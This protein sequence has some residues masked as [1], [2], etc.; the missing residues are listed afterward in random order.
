MGAV[1]AGG[2]D[3]RLDVALVSGR[4]PDLLARTL[5]SFGR[6]VLSRFS[7]RKVFANVDPFGGDAAAGAECEGLI[8]AA[9]PNAH[10]RTPLTP[11]FGGAVKWLWMQA[12]DV[13]LLHMEDDWLVLAPI[14]P[15][16]VLPLLEGDVACVTPFTAEHGRQRGPFHTRVKKRK[17]AGITWRRDRVANFG[18]SP[19]FLAGP[20]ARRC[21][22]LVDPN[23]DP[24][25]QMWPP[26]NP[27]LVSY[28][29]AF[30]ARH[31]LGPGGGPL[32]RDLGREWRATA[33]LKKVL[34]DGRSEWISADPD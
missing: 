14:G 2:A 33:G 8:R 20:F 15:E 31:L 26:H 29:Q 13:P 21:G 25:K 7:V 28:Q 30:R 17:I 27:A 11:S 32:L 23:L 24:E 3:Q 5:D 4:R 6:Q 16:D 22:E 1:T 18:T 9:F 34:R 10:V 12:G 19:R